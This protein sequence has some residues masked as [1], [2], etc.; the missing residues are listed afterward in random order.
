MRKNRCF[1]PIYLENSHFFN[2]KF[3]GVNIFLHF[4]LLKLVICVPW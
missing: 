2:K 4:C 3:V 1:I